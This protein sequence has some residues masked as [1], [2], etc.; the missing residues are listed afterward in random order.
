MLFKTSSLLLACLAGSALASPTPTKSIVE[1]ADLCGQWDSVQTG[2]YTVYNNLW[3]ASGVAGSQCFGVDK[4]SGTNIAWHA[5]WT[6]ARGSGGVK[7]YPNAVVN[8]T[9]NKLSTLKTMKSNWSWSYSGSN[10]VANVAYDLFTSSSPTATNEYEIMIWLAAYGGAGP[11]SASYGADGNP[12]PIATVT[13]AG[14]SWKLYKGSNGVNQVFSFL[15]ADG[16]IISSFS[17]D[18][19]EFVKYLTS[20]QGL[21]TSQYLISSGAGTEPTEGSN[22]KFTTSS[23]S[24]VIT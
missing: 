14:K 10:L 7:T 18:I 11:I 23:Y 5:T 22:A 16:K 3:G 8:Y 17:G 13:L 21:P 1:R 12:V 24:L 9:P 19:V 2:T 20:K 6:W 15:P 4:V